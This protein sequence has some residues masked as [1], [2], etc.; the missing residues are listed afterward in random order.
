MDRF[1]ASHIAY[2]VSACSHV[3]VVAVTVSSIFVDEMVLTYV[4][5]PRSLGVVAYSVTTAVDEY[6]AVVVGTMIRVV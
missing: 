2:T 3:L 5:V 4:K 6:V 1:E